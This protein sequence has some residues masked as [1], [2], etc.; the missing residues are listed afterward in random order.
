MSAFIRWA[1]TLPFIILVVGFSAFHTDDV[2]INLQP[3]ANNI[4]LPLFVPVIGFLFFGF[5]WGVVISWLN[6]APL[7]H[8]N[9]GL[10]KEIKTLN[11]KI[12]DL[13]N[14]NRKL[15]SDTENTQ[16]LGDNIEFLPSIQ[17]KRKNKDGLF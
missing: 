11:K 2:T 5:I 4:E 15:S 13:K 14:K 10:N 8:K 16:K 3:I 9:R 12:D 7:R 17:D 6:A 1:L